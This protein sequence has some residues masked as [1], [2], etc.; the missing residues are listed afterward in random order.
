MT[1][2][3]KLRRDIE[4]HG[5]DFTASDF[6]MYS[7]VYTTLGLLLKKGEIALV[8]YA[9]D[10]TTKPAKIFRAVKIKSPFERQLDKRIAPW[11]SVYPEFFREPTFTGTVRKH[12]L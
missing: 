10:G 6:D 5:K 11:V 3:D 8:G 9:T 4:I 7:H 2:I 1:N 12:T